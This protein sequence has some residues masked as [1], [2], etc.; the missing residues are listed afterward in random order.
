MADTGAARHILDHAAHFGNNVP[1]STTE[2]VCHLLSSFDKQSDMLRI[3]KRNIKFAKENLAKT[4]FAEDVALQ[5]LP[6]DFRFMGCMFF[7]LGYD[8][9]VVYG[10]NCSLNLA[11]TIFQNSMEEIAY[12]A[13]HEIHHIG[14]IALKGGQMPSF[15]TLKTRSD[16]ARLIEYCTHL[17]G[18]AVYTSL[19]LRQKEGAADM[20]GDYIAL[21]SPQ[22]LNNMECEFF[23]IYRHFKNNPDV[24]LSQNDFS[25]INILSDEKRLWYIVGAHIAKTIDQLLGRESLTALI[26]E[27]SENFI[28]AY[29]SAKYV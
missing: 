18:M 5:F 23:E 4:R 16:M 12:Y 26:S 25:K 22:Q 14:F 24:P 13:I 8:I 27:D 29:C 21:N 9:G 20:I 3:F 17:E 19:Y 1:A 11:H 15:G 28:N 10:K 6:K 2:L 7:T